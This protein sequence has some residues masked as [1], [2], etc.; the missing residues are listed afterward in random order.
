MRGVEKL[1][2]EM[3]AKAEKLTA[4]CRE[5][6]LPLL[7][8]ETLRSEA[9]Q[10]QLY[11]KGRSAPGKI[12]T[13]CKYPQ[14]AH[15]W[16]VAFDFCRNVKGK[17]YENCDGFFQK[18]GQLG[19]SI[20]LFW[21]GDFKS[22]KDMPHFEHPVYVVNNSVKTL[23]EKWGAPEVFMKTWAQ[24]NSF[25]AKTDALSPPGINDT[26]DAWEWA[27]RSGLAGGISCQETVTG[28]I[29]AKM[30]YRYNAMKSL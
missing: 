6:G 28:E 19:K 2:P 29:L 18:V 20:G 17:E 9:E 24:E 11:E 16:G 10:T 22:F 3:R 14:S 25:A 12:V 30:L 5:N 15:C 1:H 4:L 23:I 27:V 7:I 8:T 13:N 21:G 26:D